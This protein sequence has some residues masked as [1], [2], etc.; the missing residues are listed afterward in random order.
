MSSKGVVSHTCRVNTWSSHTQTGQPK[1]VLH[2]ESRAGRLPSDWGVRGDRGVGAREVGGG[3][4]Q[5]DRAWSR[6]QHAARQ[7][8]A[9][10]TGSTLTVRKGMTSGKSH[11]S[12]A[13]RMPSAPLET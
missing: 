2:G 8:Q 6:S 7:V 3:G 13:Q 4:Q 10:H 5:G 9:N 1:G 12:R 11:K